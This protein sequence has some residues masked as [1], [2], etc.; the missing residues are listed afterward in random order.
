MDTEALQITSKGSVLIDAPLEAVFDFISDPETRWDFVTPLEAHRLFDAVSGELLPGRYE[1]EIAGRTLSYE[2]HI[3]VLDR[4]NRIIRD[5]RGDV[6]STQLFSLSERD[7]FTELTLALTYEVEPLWPT[8]FRE[9]PTASRFSQ[10]L[11]AQ[12]LDEMRTELEVE[13][14]FEIELR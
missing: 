13:Q 12:M 11:V 2:T 9:E 10:T 7:G 3:T 8:Y 5:A 14:A 4:P 6:T 1:L